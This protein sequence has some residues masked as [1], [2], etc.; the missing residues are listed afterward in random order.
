MIPHPYGK[1]SNVTVTRDSS[2]HPKETWR[3]GIFD[4]KFKKREQKEKQLLTRL[5]WNNHSRFNELQMSMMIRMYDD[6]SKV[7]E[8]YGKTFENKN[9]DLS[10]KNWSAIP[11]KNLLSLSS[12]FFFHFS[13]S[14]RV[15]PTYKAQNN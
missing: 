2:I 8:N 3:N 10:R 7:K 13:L 4:N 6:F 1:E 15:W 5:T 9:I 11:E 14:V 12:Q